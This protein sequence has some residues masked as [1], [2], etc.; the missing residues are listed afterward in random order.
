M[1]TIAHALFTGSPSRR[2]HELRCPH[3]ALA[4]PHPSL[5]VASRPSLCWA[6][7]PPGPP[8]LRKACSYFPS[9]SSNPTA[10]SGL[11]VCWSQSNS[12]ATHCQLI[13]TSNVF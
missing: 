6:V 4:C 8:L 1:F 7:C 5:P 3:L 9:G 11:C 10:L 13:F 2:G 12:V